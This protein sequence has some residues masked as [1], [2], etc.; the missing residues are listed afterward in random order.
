MHTVHVIQ[1]EFVVYVGTCRQLH[2]VGKF[3]KRTNY[4][5]QY[6]VDKRGTLFHAES[7]ELET[8]SPSEVKAGERIYMN[9]NT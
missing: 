1:T 7:I 2:Y 9:E 8:S 4:Y 5:Q 6:E 3:G